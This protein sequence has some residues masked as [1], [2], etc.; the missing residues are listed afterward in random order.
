VAFLPTG[1]AGLNTFSAI[2]KSISRMERQNA[3][4]SEVGHALHKTGVGGGLK[5]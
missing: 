3:P 2:G 4:N 5:F 1:Q